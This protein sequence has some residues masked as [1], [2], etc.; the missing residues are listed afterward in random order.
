MEEKTPFNIF[1]SQIINWSQA[2][3]SG[4]CEVGGGSFIPEQTNYNQHGKGGM[5]NDTNRITLMQTST[6]SCGNLHKCRHSHLK[7]KSYTEIYKYIRRNREKGQRTQGSTNYLRI[8]N[9]ESYVLIAAYLFVCVLF[10]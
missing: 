4:N 2:R 1:Y 5:R 7:L 9:A 8:E 3:T 10:A 6:P